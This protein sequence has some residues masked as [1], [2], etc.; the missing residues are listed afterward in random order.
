MLSDLSHFGRLIDLL[1]GDAPSFPLSVAAAA[2]DA[3][4]VDCVFLDIILLFRL[5]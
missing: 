1:D 4:P 5:V 2:A 3:A